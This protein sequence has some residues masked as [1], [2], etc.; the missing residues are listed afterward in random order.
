ML[1]TV[2]PKVRGVMLRPS[3]RSGSGRERLRHVAVERRSRVG[4][5]RDGRRVEAGAGTPHPPIAATAPG[6]AG[7]PAAPGIDVF[8]AGE[9]SA[10]KR[11]RR[12][13]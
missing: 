6:V 13:S 2:V 1:K 4:D 11:L 12:S 8:A 5:R 3:S 7:R 9:S 10:S